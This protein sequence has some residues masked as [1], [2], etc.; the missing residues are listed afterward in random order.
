M[1]GDR[2]DDT[3]VRRQDV[4]PLAGFERSNLQRELPKPQP[5]FETELTRCDRASTRRRPLD[6]IVPPASPAVTAGQLSTRK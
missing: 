5:V 3:D 6:V 2:D 1:V 4:R